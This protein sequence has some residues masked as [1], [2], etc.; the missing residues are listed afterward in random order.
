MKIIII[1]LAALALSGCSLLGTDPMGVIN[2]IA[3]KGVAAGDAA[4]ETAQKGAK[5]ACDLLRD[6]PDEHLVIREWVWTDPET[7]QPVPDQVHL[8]CDGG[9]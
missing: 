1:P 2:V 6:R 7:G 5:E 3:E 9:L 8:V 4:R